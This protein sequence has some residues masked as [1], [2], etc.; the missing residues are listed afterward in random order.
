VTQPLPIF[1]SS[2]RSSIAI[3]TPDSIDKQTIEDILTMTHTISM[4]AFSFLGSAWYPTEKP[5]LFLN[6]VMANMLIKFKSSL[7]L[8][9]LMISLT[10][11]SSKTNVSLSPSQNYGIT[12]AITSSIWSMASVPQTTIPEPL[13]HMPCR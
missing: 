4:T 7:F 2:F 3:K 12:T 1:L 5:N 11:N 13:D 6:L 10:P 9:K 8:L